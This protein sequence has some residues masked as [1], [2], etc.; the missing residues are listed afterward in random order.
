[1]TH[2]DPTAE[3]QALAFQ[4]QALLRFASFNFQSNSQ[5]TLC[6]VPNDVRLH[7]SVT[8]DRCLRRA[9]ALVIFRVF[10]FVF[11]CFHCFSLNPRRVYVT[12]IVLWEILVYYPV[13]HWIWGNGWLAQMGT[14]DFAGGEHAH[15]ARTAYTNKHTCVAS[16][17]AA[18]RA[19]FRCASFS[20]PTGIV[21]HTTAGTGALVMAILLGRRKGYDKYHGEFPPSNLPLACIGAALLYM[22]WFG[23]NAGSALASDGTAIFAIG[24]TQMGAVSSGFVW[25]TLNWI[26]H[27]PSLVA[28]INGLIAGL[29]GVTPAAG[30]ISA[31]SAL[32][33]GVV[34]GFAS[35]GSVI[36]MKHKLRIDDA[37]DVSSV[38][39]LTGLIG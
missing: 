25:L 19:C 8:Y 26:R 6:S 32:G 37:L 18:Q 4:R 10:R 38:H 24:N 7:H 12:I 27:H 17:S 5:G 11:R 3:L 36:L 30:Y 39:G 2:A 31:Q 35:Y 22:G 15:N 13:A 20:R 16:R 29:A 33:L 14:L 21:I 9:A 34:L 1:M 23:F 28:T